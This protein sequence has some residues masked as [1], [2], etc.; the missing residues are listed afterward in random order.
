MILVVNATAALGAFGFGHL[1]DRLGSV[2][3]LAI[4]LMVWIAALSMAYYNE[5]RAGFWVVANL[6]GLALGSSQSAGRA[7]IGI[8]S[9]PARS[10]EYFGLWG[11]AAKSASVIGPLCYGL[12]TWWSHGNQR[13]ALLSTA[14]FFVL[15][16][17]VL[18]TVNER[19]GRE[20]AK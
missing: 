14:L 19:R 16:L 13:L 1:Q 20:A 17:L 9:P 8:F 3:T 6:V 11:L 4:T 18:L 7:L 2:K 12:V 15:G 10:A 5:T